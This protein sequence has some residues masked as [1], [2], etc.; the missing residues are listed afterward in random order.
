MPWSNPGSAPG[1][2]TIEVDTSGVPAGTLVRVSAVPYLGAAKTTQDVPIESCATNG[3]D[4]TATA[5]FD[6][7]TGGYVIEA[8]ATFQTP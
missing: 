4:C 3:V 2:A 7:D 1:L 8:R 5:I 6:L